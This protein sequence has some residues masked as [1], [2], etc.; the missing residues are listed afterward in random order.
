MP[1]R[2]NLLAEAQAIQEMRRRDPVKRALWAAALLISL[3]LV[4]SSSLQL[5]AMLAKKD[6]GRLE[7]QIKSHAG[8][9]QHFLDNKKKLAEIKLKLAALDRLATNRFLN[10]TLL[11][12]LQKT[13]VD[14]VQL[15]RFHVDQTYVTTQE[16]PASTNA[17][18]ALPGKPATATERI[19]VVLE[20]S[21]SCANPGDQVP[22]FKEAIAA[23][24]YFH[25]MLGK[26]NEVSLKQ[27]GT[28]QGSLETG[29]PAMLFTLECRYPEKT[30]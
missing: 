26:T 1:I 4:W 20:G 14:D 19:A 27:F 7:A 8:E 5:Q 10:G 3:V 12:A 18:R 25:S 6:L 21:D 29:R 30:R 28:L 15:V 2:L 17:T 23:N 16:A 9:Y 13:L 11:D 22:R 24:P